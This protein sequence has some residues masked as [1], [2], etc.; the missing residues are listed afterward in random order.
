[1]NSDDFADFLR[2]ISFGGICLKRARDES[3]SVS[4]ASLT[5]QTFQLVCVSRTDRRTT[6]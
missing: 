6:G 5:I 3:A 4:S 1:M 2:H